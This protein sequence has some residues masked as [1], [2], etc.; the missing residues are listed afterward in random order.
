MNQFTKFLQI[1]NDLDTE[2]IYWKQIPKILDRKVTIE[3]ISELWKEIKE[4]GFGNRTIRGNIEKSGAGKITQSN[5]FNVFK[6][7]IDI[8]KK[9]GVKGNER[10]KS[11]IKTF[12]KRQCL[13]YIGYNEDEV[14]EKLPQLIKGADKE[15]TKEQI[16]LTKEITEKICLSIPA[17]NFTKDKELEKITVL[18]AVLGCL[19]EIKS[20]CNQRLEELDKAEEKEKQEKENAKKKANKKEE[21]KILEEEA[22]PV[23]AKKDESEPGESIPEPEPEPSANEPE[24][25]VEP[26]EPDLVKKIDPSNYYLNNKLHMVGKI[27]GTYDVGGKLKIL[28]QA[29]SNIPSSYVLSVDSFMTQNR[30]IRKAMPD[31]PE[32][33]ENQVF[34]MSLKTLGEESYADMEPSLA[35]T[36]L[37]EKYKGKQI[38]FQSKLEATKTG[39]KRE[40][41]LDEKLPFERQTISTKHE[42]FIR[43]PMLDKDEWKTFIQEGGYEKSFRFWNLEADGLPKYVRVE[44][45]IYDL[46]DMVSV[47][48]DGNIVI[49]SEKEFSWFEFNVNKCKDTIIQKPLTDEDINVMQYKGL[50]EAEFIR[51]TFISQRF[52]DNGFKKA[53]AKAETKPIVIPTAEEPKIESQVPEVKE[54]V[55][56]PTLPEEPTIVNE[57]IPSSPMPEETMAIVEEEVK[58]EVAIE[59]P[60]VHESMSFYLEELRKKAKKDHSF[61][62]LKRDIVNFHCCLMSSP[63]TI[64]SG[65]S[66]TGKTQLPLCYAEYFNLGTEEENGNSR[67]LFVP[68]SP[69]YN[70][71][72]DLLGYYNPQT[73]CYN[74]SENGLV[75]F[76]IKASKNPDKMYLVLFD[77]MNLAPIELYFAPFLSL[78][79][80]NV[81]ERRL[82]LFSNKDGKDKNGIPSS[83]LLSDNVK[84][85]GTINLDITTKDLSDRLLDRS[86]VIQLHRMS[87]TEMKKDYTLAE[88]FVSYPMGLD[89]LALFKETNHDNKN[90][91]ELFSESQVAFLDDLDRLFTEAN[92]EKGLSY[93][94]VRNMSLYLEASRDFDALT[95]NEYF[96]LALK[97]NV[98]K[99]INGTSESLLH[100]LGDAYKEEETC[101]LEQL[102]LERNDISDFKEC[103]EEIKEKR[104]ALRLHGYTR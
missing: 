90:Y 93:R 17:E 81:G 16:Q 63:I 47:D 70:E 30:K 68:V 25:I 82:Y 45:R 59:T 53:A 60:I 55:P 4:N 51:P 54:K 77:E 74:P 46:R 58:E 89:P 26:E 85:V 71:P 42:D 2:K 24:A 86:S 27:L 14:E 10:I 1:S 39:Y 40:A 94:S 57:S 64:L 13:R 88:D 67:F 102:L 15:E 29:I 50:Y 18:A 33:D 62:Y 38:V 80:K 19:E 7:I 84:F 43:V 72:S 34:P 87:F 101:P 49:T 32:G 79:E 91:T 35:I 21:A 100:I 12:E 8:F 99:K 95:E 20:I 31:L 83:I 66:G 56:E 75:D 6:T 48:I 52:L 22:K 5:V 92:P 23:D 69:S 41:I 65:M 104:T 11:E 44:N 73:Q 97:Q 37:D 96:D 28:V 98:L 61:L 3:F 78:F 9:N 36:A 103:I 76:L